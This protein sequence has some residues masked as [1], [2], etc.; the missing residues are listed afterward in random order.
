MS[1][2]TRDALKVLNLEKLP[3]NI[4]DLKRAWREVIKAVHPD[5]VEALNNIEISKEYAR[6]TKLANDAL[7]YLKDKIN[8][9]QTDDTGNKAY[10]RNTYIISLDTLINVYDGKEII[11]K[12]GI[13]I[14]R[15]LL[16]N[17]DII[18]DIPIYY[19][20][21]NKRYDVDGYVKYNSRDTYDINIVINK[22]GLVGA[23]KVVVGDKSIDSRLNRGTIK[24]I[25]KFRYIIEVNINI[26]VLEA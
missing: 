1:L 10:K 6:R 21:N 13:K 25:Y 9:S 8:K 4:K 3:T 22:M 16:L 7:E 23:I 11:S 2:D 18:I 24:L 26:N 14:N 5:S 19:I 12:D 15:S 17:N 20:Y